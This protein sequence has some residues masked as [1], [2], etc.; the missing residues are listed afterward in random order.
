MNFK[1]ENNLPNKKGLS[2]TVISLIATIIILVV[3]IGLLANYY[4]ASQAVIEQYKSIYIKLMNKNTE[5]MNEN[6]ELTEKLSETKIKLKK[7]SY[8]LAEAKISLTSAKYKL[9]EATFELG[10][11]MLTL[12]ELSRKFDCDDSALHMY[13]YFT[14]LGYDVSIVAGNLDLDNE[15]FYQCDHVWVWVDDGIKR[16]L[17]YDLGRL[18]NDEQHS[19]GYI[20]SYR[21]LLKEA[22][23]DQ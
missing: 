1:S 16:E 2:K 12:P 5:L 21:D 22:L 14:S 15:T 19:F 10:E 23:R 8:N 9:E 3:G 11:D 18:D 6:V 7:T 20:I 4:F 13:L 17:S